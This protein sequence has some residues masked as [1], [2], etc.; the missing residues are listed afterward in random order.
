MPYAN[1]FAQY[2]SVKRMAENIRIKEILRR[3]KLAE[4][5][6]PCSCAGERLYKLISN[7]DAANVN[8]DGCGTIHDILPEYVLSVDGS[9]VEVPVSNGST[10]AKIAY[11]TINDVLLQ[12]KKLQ[13][14]DLLR[15]ADPRDIRKTKT[16]GTADTVLAGCN[17]I[18]EGEVDPQSSFRRGVID[19]FREQRA[20]E[21]GET[22]LDTYEALLAYKPLV[23]AQS[24]PYGDM[25]KHETP[26][27]AFRRISG[28]HACECSLKLPCHST[29]A[30]RV[31]EQFNPLGENGTAVGEILHVTE[32]LWI[33]H[34]LRSLE[35]HGMLGV[36]ARMAIVLDGPLAV[37]GRPGWLSRAI[38]R[39]L[40]RINGLLRKETGKDLLL[41][42]IEKSGLFVEHFSRLCAEFDSGTGSVEIPPKTA[43]L[44]TDE[45]I[46]KFVVL[47]KNTHPY[48]DVTY[49]GR[50]FFYRTK[51]GAQVVATLPFLNPGHRS[52]ERAELQQFPR[53][54]DALNLFDALGSS[55]YS[56]AIIPITLAHAEAA[57]P[58]RMGSRVLEALA[59]D[60]I[61]AAA[62]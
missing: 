55:R 28:T 8:G 31:Y 22:L 45:Y 52:L 42:G 26:Q 11:A 6:A 18:Y 59:A 48:G 57:I 37:F 5:P 1:E 20:F 27:V 21:T 50:K 2:N 32:R 29:D 38:S 16:V 41:I 46:R 4:P 62:G 47:T 7:P 14:L 40:Y 9:F 39:E 36:L 35:Q 43:L 33:I 51:S 30:L 56:N 34:I 54:I 10:A 17:I 13:E 53:L 15:P 44:P 23:P 19:L 49:F 61:K 58:S 3:Y 60:L 24:C 12:L 25:C